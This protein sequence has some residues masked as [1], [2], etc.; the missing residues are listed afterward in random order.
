[1]SKIYTSSESVLKW[2]DSIKSHVEE[3]QEE[4][5]SNNIHLV[6]H[7]GLHDEYIREI[8]S[9]LKALQEEF[10]IDMD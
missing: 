9:C 1:M 4:S 2:L 6:L 8:K 7:D 3:L 5:G 10:D